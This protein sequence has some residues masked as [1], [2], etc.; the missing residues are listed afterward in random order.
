LLNQ[1]VQIV[2]AVADLPKTAEINDFFYCKTEN[3]LAVYTE[4]DSVKQWKQ[5]NPDTDTNTDTTVTGLD[6]TVT[7]NADNIIITFTLDQ[8]TTNEIDSSTTALPQKST[9][10]TIPIANIIEGGLGLD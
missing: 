3:I 5:I 2:N 6:N 1:T 9:T 7:V 8:T 10:I 4:I